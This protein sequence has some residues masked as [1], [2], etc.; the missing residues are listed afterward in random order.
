L[1]GEVLFIRCGLPLH[2]EARTS[3][4]GWANRQGQRNRIYSFQRYKR[5]EQLQ[6]QDTIWRKSKM[7][8]WIL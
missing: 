1:F 2:S 6:I 5:A 7:A 3:I 4:T 8:G